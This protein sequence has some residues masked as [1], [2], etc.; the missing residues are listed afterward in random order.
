MP[1]PRSSGIV[2]GILLAAAGSAQ[3]ASPTIE[4]SAIKCLVAGKYRKMPAKFAPEE[5]AQPRVYFRPEGVPSWYYVE[6]K[7][8]APLGH[9]G[10]L[11][12]PTKKLVG[13]KIEYYLEAASKDFDTGRTPEYTPVVVARDS[14]CGNDPVLALYS[15]EPPAAVF[16]SVPQGFAIGGGVAGGTIAAVVGG[17]AAAG[18]AAVALS[19]D[20]DD[21]A[22][23]P[24][25]VQ[26][27]PTPTP[28]P[29]QPTPPPTTD[30]ADVACQAD[31]R[32]GTAP[33]QVKFNAQATGGNG[34]Y[35]FV[36]TFGDGGTSNQV[37]PSHTYTQPGTYEGRVVVTSGDR[38]ASCGR[39]I[40]VRSRSFRLDVSPAGTGTGRIT[41]D[42]IDCPGDCSEDYAPGATVA[43]AAQ[44]TGGSTF[45][46]WGGDCSGGGACTL[47]MDRDRSVSATF[48]AP[49]N[50]T[51]TVNLGGT[52]TGIVR[53][54][55]INCPGDCT[56][57]FPAGTPVTLSATTTGGSGFGG[58]GDDCSSFTGTTCDL[59]MNG[60]R[61]ASASF[62]VPTF[63]LTIRSQHL[64][65]GTGD[66]SIL[67]AKVGPCNSGPAPGNTC[68]TDWSPGTVL[69]LRP[70]SFGASFMGWGGD[71]ALALARGS[72]DCT[73]TMSQDRS[74]VATWQDLT[75]QGPGRS[76]LLS[77]FEVAGA[78]GQ[79]TFNGTLLSEPKPGVTTLS[80]TTLDGENRLEAQLIEAGR[81]GTWRFDLAD[82][83][84][85][86]RGTLRVLAG[87]ALAVGPDSVVF[88]MSGRAGERI[89]F[90][91]SRR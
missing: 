89:G 87:E 6:M 63:R 39:V 65:T 41:G 20:D 38:V 16:P 35:D 5:V 4:H 80:V 72:N 10:V 22:P 50:F 29:V 73:L 7:P 84:G 81:A 76:T 12:K 11:P 26:P 36:W 64:G 90:A 59:T 25:P 21:P 55:G 78:R 24:P 17:A 58:W 61:T 3:A 60:P 32:Q 23:P 18:G 68:T 69:T 8:E 40:T 70:N 15:N 67:G 45:G 83:P 30:P 2:L 91:F 48:G 27:T 44:G 57:T 75:L 47:V 53:G 9:V 14:E 28:P 19:M 1:A 88:R 62:T 37:N 82:V 33:L 54:T 42:G 31:P 56:E 85:L 46:G 52:G 74:V 49:A 43:L 13:Q 34:T 79:A 86:E 51:L 77:R 71:C 66:V